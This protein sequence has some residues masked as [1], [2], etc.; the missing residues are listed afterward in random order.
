MIPQAKKPFQDQMFDDGPR[1][2]L[3]GQDQPVLD[4]SLGDRI[5]RNAARSEDQGTET[6]KGGEIQRRLEILRKS[7]WDS[8]TS[9]E[10]Y[11]DPRGTPP[12][13]YTSDPGTPIGS[14]DQNPGMMGPPLLVRWNQVYPQ[15]NCPT[16]VLEM[17][18]ILKLQ[19][20]QVCFWEFLG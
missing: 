7:G 11:H 17:S 15:I 13:A 18:E 19:L 6:Q 16:L 8:D 3:G 2:R 10:I 14:F 20:I 1:S 9:S 4:Q 5:P 12:P